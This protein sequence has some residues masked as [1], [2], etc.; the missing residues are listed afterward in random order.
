MIKITLPLFALMLIANSAFAQANFISDYYA[1]H[2]KDPSFTTVNVSSKTFSLFTDIETNDVDEQKV[3]GAIAKLDGIK[4]VSKE[5]ASNS[6]ILYQEAEN[7]I[8]NDERYEELARVNAQEDNFIFMIREVDDLV[9][10][11]TI[12]VGS[13]DH[14]LIATLFGDIDLNNI[15]RL[16]KVIRTQGKDWFAI[17]ENIDSDELVFEG[18]RRN[19]KNTKT[20]KEASDDE[21]AI[22][23]FPNPVSDYVRLEAKDAADTTYELQFFSIIGEPIKNIGR[24]NLPY[25]IQLEDLPSGAYFLRLT[26]EKGAFKNFRIVKP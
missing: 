11:L 17:F 12:I 10:E 1:H 16:T 6:F 21:I 5:K 7:T 13:D 26:N 19:N 20:T 18:A 15:S 8:L 3:L 4:V 25:Q 2:E 14:F 24:V 9:K 23:V 22:S